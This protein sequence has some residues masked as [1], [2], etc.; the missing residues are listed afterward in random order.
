MMKPPQVELKP[1]AA[2]YSTLNVDEPS[3]QKLPAE[4]D[5]NHA[6]EEKTHQTVPIEDSC[7]E[8]IHNELH[9]V[10]QHTPGNP[11]NQNSGEASATRTPKPSS[12]KQAVNDSGKP[13][14]KRFRADSPS[15][16]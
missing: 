7:L 15:G 12:P 4:E 6:L 13:R 9:G 8:N 5:V 16:R 10:S 3:R 2:V 14:S 11:K 1:D